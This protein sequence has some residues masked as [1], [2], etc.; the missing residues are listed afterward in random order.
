MLVYRNTIDFCV[1]TLYPIILLNLTY[2]FWEIFLGSLGFSLHVVMLQGHVIQ[3]SFISSF[4]MGIHLISFSCLIT[5]ARTFDPRSNCVGS[6][7]S[8]VGP[9]LSWKAF[10]LSSLNKMLAVE[11]LAVL[12]QVE[13]VPFSNLLRVFIIIGHWILSS[14]FFC[15]NWYDHVVFLKAITVV[16]CTT[17]CIFEYRLI[18]EYWIRLAFLE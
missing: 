2:W 8:S 12:C 3:N 17:I 16:D 13:E 7:E 18:F 9:S 11:F 1:L 4:P 5:L 14:V 6:D 10:G 15:L